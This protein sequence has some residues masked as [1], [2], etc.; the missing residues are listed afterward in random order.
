[1]QQNSSGV[2]NF[3]KLDIVAIM[4]LAADYVGS[5]L[6]P[7][8][9]YIIVGNE[10]N[11]HTTKDGVSVLKLMSSTS[12]HVNNVLEIIKEGAENA[13]KMAGDGTTSSIV[14]ANEMLKGL[15]TKAFSEDALKTKVNKMLEKL[16]KIKQE[17]SLDKIKLIINTALSGDKELADIVFKAFEMNNFS[18][19]IVAEIGDGETRVEMINGFNLPCKIPSPEVFVPSGKLEIMKPN[20]VIYA[21]T[22][23]TERE[24]INAIDKA[25]GYGRDN[26]IIIANNFSQEALSILAIN[27][28]RK[29][30][31]AIPVIVNP[32]DLG[33]TNLSNLLSLVLG[34]PLTGEDVSGRL[35]YIEPNYTGA[36]KAIITPNSITIE[37]IT[38]HLNE[39]SEEYKKLVKGLKEAHLKAKDDLEAQKYSYLLSILTKRMVKIIVSSNIPNKAKEMKDRIDD[40]LHSIKTALVYGVVEGGGRAYE[41]LHS[42]TGGETE[43]ESVFNVISRKVGEINREALDSARV[44]EA[45]LKTALDLAL[46]LNNISYV[47]VVQTKRS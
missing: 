40:A 45:V 44:I 9:K 35:D 20:I 38:N 41:R 47:T 37:E 4:N 17:P 5:T 46:L 12:P 29:I 7:R 26:I 23:E 27:H 36:K 14:M 3:Q 42:L 1:M 43:F 25:V 19:Y 24:V 10:N 8:G 11:V 28:I 34:A 6:G 39:N 13:L 32:G 15:A 33:T 18:P 21:G 31:N 2:F 16:N 30:I 22:V